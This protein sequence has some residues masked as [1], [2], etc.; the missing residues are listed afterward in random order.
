MSLFL[1]SV[2]KR[3][4][5]STVRSK[6]SSLT[7]WNICHFH[8]CLMLLTYFSDFPWK[9][10][11]PGTI[12]AT[13]LIELASEL[14]ATEWSRRAWAY[15][16]PHMHFPEAPVLSSQHCKWCFPYSPVCFSVGCMLSSKMSVKNI[17]TSRCWRAT[18]AFACTKT[19]RLTCQHSILIL[20][21]ALRLMLYSLGISAT[22]RLCFCY[23][24]T[25]PLT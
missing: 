3:K 22:F 25:F 20:F 18:P 21:V 7:G 8:W 24:A 11:V 17:W 15:R 19:H 23:S 2:I 1:K 14:R 4:I 12:F 5:K 10:L 9:T 16:A 13:T 6:Y